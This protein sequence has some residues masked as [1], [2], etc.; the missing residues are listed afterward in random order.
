[1]VIGVF[2]WWAAQGREARSSDRGRPLRFLPEIH[3]REGSGNRARIHLRPLGGRGH[4]HGH[5]DWPSVPRRWQP[6]LVVVVVLVGIARIVHGVHLPADVIGGWAFGTLVG[7]A[8]VSVVDRWRVRHPQRLSS[9]FRLFH[10]LHDQ[11]ARR[12]QRLDRADALTRGI[13]LAVGVH[14]RRRLVGAEV[15][16]ARSNRSP[17]L[18]GEALD[19]IGVLVVVLGPLVADRA[20]GLAAVRASHGRAVFRR[21]HAARPCSRVPSVLRAWR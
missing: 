21:A 19:L 11:L 1:M 20:H 15:Q 16:R 17:Q 14:A 7:I 9:R 2:T 5:G 4:D 6:L 13:A 8:G 10:E 12:N 18:L 3:V